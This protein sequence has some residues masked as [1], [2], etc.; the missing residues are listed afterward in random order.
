MRS[1]IFREA[2][3]ARYIYPMS[4]EFKAVI[5]HGFKDEEAIAI[6]RAVKALGLGAPAP[7]FAVTTPASREWKVDYLLEHLAEEHAMARKA[8][9]ITP[10][11]SRES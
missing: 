4:S 2:R 10:D 1:R 7:A 8:G 11:R 3:V 5:L 6:M 9:G